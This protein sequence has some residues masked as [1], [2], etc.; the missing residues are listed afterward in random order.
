MP[1]ITIQG[2]TIAFPNS[3]TSPNWAEAVIEFAQATESALASVVG[4]YDVAL[5]TFDFDSS[6]P[7]S[8]VDIPNL[9]FPVTQVRAATIEYAIDRTTSLTEVTEKG[10]L[11]IVYNSTNSSSNKWEV[12]RG[13]VADS[14][15]SFTVTDVGQV[16]IST[17]ALSGTS[18]TGRITYEAKALP[19]SS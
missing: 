6:N 2:K 18:H 14:S 12:V 5:Q 3:G 1:D 8:D 11:E 13:F 9:N 19:Q 10:T 17:T 16:Q 15:V 4:T 7:G